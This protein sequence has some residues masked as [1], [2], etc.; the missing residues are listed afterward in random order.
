MLK[1]TS[2][3][4]LGLIGGYLLWSGDTQLVGLKYRLLS[5]ERLAVSHLSSL[6]GGTQD[7]PVQPGQTS[8]LAPGDDRRD[9]PQK[10]ISDHVIAAGHEK[11][12]VEPGTSTKNDPVG[13]SFSAL[14]PAQQKHALVHLASF[15]TTNAARR[16]WEQLKSRYP[17]QLA[18]LNL[19]IERVELG[20][21]GIFYRVLTDPI[22]RG[23]SARRLCASL[24]TVNQYCSV[25]KSETASVL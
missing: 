2:I 7:R 5:Y 21:Q 24:Q 17:A 8:D 23:F 4:I 10:S 3:A 12:K 13:T 6:Q 16:E 19:I 25:L 18:D 22:E 20:S 11:S 1:F 15:R 14:E 9:V